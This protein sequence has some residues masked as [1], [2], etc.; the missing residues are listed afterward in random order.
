MVNT[1]VANLK[2]VT[3]LSIPLISTAI[4]LVLQYYGNIYLLTEKRPSVS[5]YSFIPDYQGYQN[6]PG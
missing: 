3:K 4:L 5:L 1:G 2:I 6:Q